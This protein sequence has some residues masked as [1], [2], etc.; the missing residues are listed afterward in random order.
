LSRAKN[1]VAGHFSKRNSILRNLPLP[2]KWMS[3]ESLKY[4]FFDERTDVWSFGI[5]IWEIMSKGAIPFPKVP[6]QPELFVAYLEK[7][8]RPKQPTNCPDDVYEVMKTCLE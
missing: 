1:D 5:V 8:N 7:G 2:V 3:P 4:Q 6:T